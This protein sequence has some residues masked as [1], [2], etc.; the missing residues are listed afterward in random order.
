MDL[1]ERKDGNEKL[2]EGSGGRKNSG[3][4]I[5]VVVKESLIS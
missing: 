4:V 3:Q 1:G 2:G 5:V